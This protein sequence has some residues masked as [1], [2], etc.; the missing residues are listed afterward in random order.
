MTKREF[1]EQYAIRT[2][3]RGAEWSQD[4]REQTLRNAEGWW[5]ALEK[6]CPQPRRLPPELE[7]K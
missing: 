2:G 4:E 5:E 3:A 6:V 1:L 7:R